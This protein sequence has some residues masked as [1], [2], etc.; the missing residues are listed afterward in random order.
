M[1]LDVV[2]FQDGRSVKLDL[3]KQRLGSSQTV[4]DRVLDQ[5]GNGNEWN[6]ETVSPYHLH[7]VTIGPGV[8]QE[9]TA[10]YSLK[11]YSP[12]RE[13]QQVLQPGSENEEVDKSEKHQVLLN[14]GANE[15]QSIT[16]ASVEKSTNAIPSTWLNLT[17]SKRA[18]ENESTQEDSFWN[19]EGENDPD[20][21][22]ETI[23]EEEVSKLEVKIRNEYL[24]SS[25]LEYIDASNFLKSNYRGNW[26]LESKSTSTVRLLRRNLQQVLF[27]N[28]LTVPCQGGLRSA[29]YL[30]HTHFLRHLVSP[31]SSLCMFRF[32][33]S[34]YAFLDGSEVVDEKL[35][36]Y[37]KL[38]IKNTCEGHLDW[39][40]DVARPYQR[41]WADFYN[42]NGLYYKIDQ[43]HARR[44]YHG[45]VN[46]IKL[47]EFQ[48]LFQTLND[49]TFVLQK[50]QKRLGPW[51]ESLEMHRDPKSDMWISYFVDV[52]VDWLDPQYRQDESFELPVYVI[53]QHILLWK[54]LSFVFQLLDDANLK[55]LP[56]AKSGTSEST[57]SEV[58]NWRKTFSPSKLRTKI[59]D[60]F[61]Y[62]QTQNPKESDAQVK[63]AAAPEEGLDNDKNVIENAIEEAGAPTK[64]AATLEEVR[65][66]EDTIKS[67]T[68]IVK[69]H[70]TKSL[71]HRQAIDRVRRKRVLAFRW[72]GNDKPRYLWYSWASPIFEGVNSGFFK[73]ESSSRV[74][75]DT[76]EAQRV[77]HEPSWVKVARYA[78]ALRAAQYGQSLDVTM[79]ADRM[80]S[81]VK[82]RLLKCFYSNGTFPTQLDLTSKQPTNSWPTADSS[83]E[84]FEIPLLLLQEEF[85]CLDV[86]AYLPV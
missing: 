86:A 3:S 61:T 34:M 67:Y 45:A 9:L 68:E 75:K 28:S 83:P 22:V 85:K 17:G 8:T 7:T 13:P 54:A 47:Y 82:D 2:L 40:F 6:A 48:M 33:L 27:V 84:V 26:T 12:N 51:F 59:M 55:V 4:R 37:L 78:L 52:N 72:A 62:E 1:Q 25:G 19:Y 15:S 81:E 65:G 50:L 16:A 79:D 73:G 39:I 44:W 53:S 56:L 63:D 23:S 41:G 64:A 49:R 71:K 69:D 77:H 66:D 10:L 18:K 20:D 21:L 11:R 57:T 30:S 70:S 32:L 5:P 74:W 43:S 46:F 38:Q 14:D 29:I 31:W 35:R 58:Y 60:H 24:L 36:D 76:L 42:P 80:R